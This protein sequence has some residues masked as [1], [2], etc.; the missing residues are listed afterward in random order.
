MVHTAAV[1]SLEESMQSRFE[2]VVFFYDCTNSAVTD[3][4]VLIAGA[5]LLH[6]PTL[7]RGL[8]G[9]IALGYDKC[10]G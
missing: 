3:S 1:H 4:K 9:M 2:A 8:T 5:A 6:L 10:A 7:H